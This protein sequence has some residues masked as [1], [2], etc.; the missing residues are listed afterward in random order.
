M[1]IIQNI[2]NNYHVGRIVV[3]ADKALNSGDNV[4]FLRVKKDGFIFSQTIRGSNA[5]FQDYVFDPSG[6]RPLQEPEQLRF[7]QTEFPGFGGEKAGASP[8]DGESSADVFRVKSRVHPQEFWVTHHD[9][10]KRRIPI[11][12]RQVVYYSPSYAK[13][14]A[15][16][17]GRNAG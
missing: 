5:E 8:P 13:L 4:A 14:P 7:L 1:P 11:D 6:Y 2:R 16:S 15:I 3:V 17:S 10:K 12:V 9:G